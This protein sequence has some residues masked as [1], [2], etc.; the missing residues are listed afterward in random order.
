MRTFGANGGDEADDTVAFQKAIDSGASTVFIPVGK[1]ILDG[2]VILRGKVTR[3]IGVRGE[4]GQLAWATPAGVTGGVFQIGKDAQKLVAF[5]EH[6]PGQGPAGVDAA[7][8]PRDP[9]RR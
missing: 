2:N 1:F 7:V 9:R 5:A 8:Q 3:I 4:W 6:H